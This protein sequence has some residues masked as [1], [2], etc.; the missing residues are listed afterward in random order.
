LKLFLS[1]D[2]LGNP[3]GLFENIGKDFSDLANNTKEGF[4]NGPLEGGLGLAVGTANLLRH[5]MAGL[6]NSMDK[7]AG[8]LA[9]GMTAITS[10]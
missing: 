10:D 2:I 3:V 9:K 4:S 8:S 1:I 6:L 7:M 5:T